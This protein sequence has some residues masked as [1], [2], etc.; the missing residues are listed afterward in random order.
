[1]ASIAGRL[2]QHDGRECEEWGDF[3]ETMGNIGFHHP[4]R[5]WERW[6]KHRPTHEPTHENGLIGLAGRKAVSYLF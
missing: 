1:M 2:T 4:G 5:C 6:F 3:V